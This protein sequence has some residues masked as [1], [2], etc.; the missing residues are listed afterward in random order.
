MEQTYLRKQMFWLTLL[1]GNTE[2]ASSGR[3]CFPSKAVLSKPLSIKK[4]KILPLLLPVP[5]ATSLNLPPFLTQLVEDI[6]LQC[7]CCPHFPTNSSVCDNK[8]FAPSRM[9]TSSPRQPPMSFPPVSG[10]ALSMESAT[11]SHSFLEASLPP[12]AHHRLSALLPLLWVLPLLFKNFKLLLF[13]KSFELCGCFIFWPHHMPYAILVSPAR[14]WTC[15]SCLISTESKPL[16]HQG[17]PWV[18]LLISLFPA[19]LSD[20]AV[21]SWLPSLNLY[22]LPVQPFHQHQQC[23]WTR[24]LIK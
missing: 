11:F 16:D 3:Q 15:A 17:S 4:K 8:V 24:V 9:M 10:S 2:K 7:P 13:F 22:P 12:F 20:S 23:S 5:P 1:L 21:P 14:D 6:A 18:L 19:T